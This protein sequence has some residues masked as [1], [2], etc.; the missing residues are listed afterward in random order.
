MSL[1][2]TFLGVLTL[3]F[4][5]SL[6]PFSIAAMAIVIVG[7]ASLSRGIVFIVTTF[8]I[9]L[10]G[11]ILILSGWAAALKALLPH[12][13]PMMA[14]IGWIGLSAACWIGAGLLWFKSPDTGETPSSTPSAKAL[15]GVFVFALGSTVSDLPTAV[16]YFAA[17]P[18]ILA[19]HSPPFV[20]G[21]WLAFYSLIYVSPLILLLWLRHF[22]SSQFDPLIGKIRSGMDLLLRRWC[23]P[24]L[25]ASGIWAL[26]QG[27]GGLSSAL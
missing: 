15:V 13:T 17:V 16:P 19:T 6:N 18:M 9:Y 7:Q 27:L 20:L 12:F 25:V 22:A 23:P 11:G 26:V 2:A 8:L 5:D 24:L 3:A 14:T 1:F 21:L 10:L 4:L